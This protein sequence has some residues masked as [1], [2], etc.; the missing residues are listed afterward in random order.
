MS[1]ETTV[2]PESSVVERTAEDEE[3]TDFREDMRRTTLLAPGICGA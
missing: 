3:E 2:I 1:S